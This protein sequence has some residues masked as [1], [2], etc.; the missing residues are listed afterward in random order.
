MSSD[1]VL[2]SPEWARFEDWIHTILGRYCDWTVI[3]ELERFSGVN[4]EV[5]SETR[6]ILSYLARNKEESMIKAFEYDGWDTQYDQGGVWVEDADNGIICH[7]DL[8]EDSAKVFVTLKDKIGSYPVEWKLWPTFENYL[9]LR[10]DRNANFLDPYN[11]KLVVEIPYPAD[12]GPV[13]V[14]TDYLQDYLAARDMVL[15]RQHD[16]RRHWLELIKDLPES[17][18]DGTV[19]KEKWGCYTLDVR[20]S[21]KSSTDR[22]S[23]LV[24]KDMVTPYERAGTI[25]GKRQKFKGPTKDYPEF[26][27]SKGLDGKEIRQ[28]PDPSDILYPTYFDPRVLKRYYDEP[29]RY[30]VGFHAPGMGGVSFLDRWSIPIGRNDEGLI[31]VWLGDLAKAGLSYEDIVHWRAHNVPPRGGMATDFWNAQMMCSPSKIPSLET[32][33]I[34]CKHEI[35]KAIEARKKTVYKHYKGPDKH[36]EKT[37][38]IPLFN[39]HTEFE[40]TILL[41]SRMFIEYLDIERFR[42]DLPDKYKNDRSLGPMVIFSNWLERAID[43][44]IDTVEALKRALQTIQKARSKTG[45]AHRF[46]D[47]SY[48]EIIQSLRLSGRVTAK[49][50]Y[51]SIAEPL[52]DSLEEICKALGAVNSLWWIKH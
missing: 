43:I 30:S 18:S 45:A 2:G 7:E 13:R 12:K 1:I 8:G 6:A 25:G 11:G 41:L 14:R 33:L 21:K 32:R 16:H 39:E 17:E 51:C 4:D 44:P 10:N 34:Y 20:N 27:T 46:S 15:I 52:A 50:L 26:I 42:N 38:R 9:G 48:Q 31:V 29:S 5:F 3:A 28:K 22:F 19:V 47:S 49:S 37:L 24:A 40:E 23:R 35:T 36:V